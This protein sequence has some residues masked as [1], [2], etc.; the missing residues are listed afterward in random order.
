M[1]SPARPR[2]APAI[3][4]L[5]YRP[6]RYDLGGGDPMFAPVALDRAAPDVPEPIFDRV[7]GPYA[8]RASDEEP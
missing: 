5:V 6:K 8:G 7:S 3:R 4:R 2:R 1:R